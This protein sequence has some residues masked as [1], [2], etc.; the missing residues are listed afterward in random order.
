MKTLVFRLIVG[1][2][3]VWAESV[4]FA[5]VWEAMPVEFWII[6]YLGCIPTTYLFDG[7]LRLWRKW[8]T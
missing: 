4:I 5:L 7:V 1:V 2:F 3:V 6:T 8:R